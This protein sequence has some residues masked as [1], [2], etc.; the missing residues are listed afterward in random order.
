MSAYKLD[1]VIRMWRVGKL[2][3]EQAIG[4]ILQLVQ[5]RDKRLQ[6]LEGRVSALRQAL[7][8]QGERGTG[9]ASGR[10]EP[11]SGKQ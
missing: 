4:Q 8:G 5:E 9:P 7:N 1:E 3:I 6:E 10:R 2:T 11:G